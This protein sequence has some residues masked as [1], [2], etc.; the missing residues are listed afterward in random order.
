[1]CVRGIKI[2]QH[3][4]Y[5]IDDWKVLRKLVK[6]V[7]KKMNQTWLHFGLLAVSFQLRFR[8][9]DGPTFIPACGVFVLRQQTNSVQ[10][11]QQV[12]FGRHLKLHACSL[13]LHPIITYTACWRL[14]FNLNFICWLGQCRRYIYYL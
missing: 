10:K 3:S 2:T 13:A 14:A 6:T 4:K 11:R 8:A 1:M 7:L 5:A 12:L 9:Q